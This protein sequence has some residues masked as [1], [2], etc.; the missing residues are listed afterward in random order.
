MVDARLLLGEPVAGAQEL[1]RPQQ[2]L[3][4]CC[5]APIALQSLLEFAV[6][7]DTGKA[8]IC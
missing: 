3:R 6:A 1:R 5:A 8:E 2:S 7:A 4:T